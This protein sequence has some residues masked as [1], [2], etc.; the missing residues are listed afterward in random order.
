MP[1]SSSGAHPGSDLAVR[2]RVTAPAGVRWIRLRYRH[3]NQKEDYQTLP[4]IEEGNAGI[5]R[6]IIPGA[7]IT[8]QWDLMYYIEIV[9]ANGTGKIY[10]DLEHDTPYIIQPVVHHN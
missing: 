9:D 4:M 2:A 8:P 1:G 10:P 3:V 6:A 5:Y 7:F